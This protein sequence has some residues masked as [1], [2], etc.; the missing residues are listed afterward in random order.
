M[1][2]R[3]DRDFASLLDEIL[4]RPPQDRG[5][6]GP[7]VHLDHLAVAEELHSGR[8]VISP[9]RVAAEYRE[10]GADA[11][12]SES[13][14]LVPELVYPDT[15]PQSVARELGLA[16]SAV[17]DDLDALRRRFALANHPD[18][19]EER[20]RSHAMKR[21]QVANMLIDAAK[22]ARRRAR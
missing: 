16:D 15:D 1:G 6:P 12:G 22:R 18:R 19:V 13:P 7:S 14:P 11:A 21:M 10:T 9:E 17:P 5:A 20:L 2:A 8:I 4:A 3:D